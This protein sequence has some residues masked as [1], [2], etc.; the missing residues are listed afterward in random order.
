MIRLVLILC[1][2]LIAAY[3]LGQAYQWLKRNKVRLT[4]SRPPTGGEILLLSIAFR[5]VRLLLQGLLR[6]I[7]FP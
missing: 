1:L 4:L 5:A 7:R 2:V 3:A 6:F